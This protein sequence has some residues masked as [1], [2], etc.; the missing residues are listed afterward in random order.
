ML[1]TDVVGEA[2]VL[3]NAHE[4]SRTEIAQCFL[5]KFQRM[6]VLVVNA[7]A[8]ESDD[9]HALFLIAVLGNANDLARLQWLARFDLDR[10]G[11]LPRTE[12]RVDRGFH[13]LGGNVA[14]NRKNTVVRNRESPVKLQ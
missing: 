14:E 9:D 12:L 11:A 10:S 5:Q 6:P 7:H 2:E 8:G 3:A 13:A 4:Q 1:G